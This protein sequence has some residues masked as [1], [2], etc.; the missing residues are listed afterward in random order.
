LPCSGGFLTAP[1]PP[2]KETENPVGSWK[3]SNV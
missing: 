1:D 3:N 2:V